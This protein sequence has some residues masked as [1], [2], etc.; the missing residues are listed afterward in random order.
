M[1]KLISGLVSFL[2]AGAVFALSQSSTT[3]WNVTDGTGTNDLVQV[4][5]SGNLKIAGSLTAGGA[6]YVTTANSTYTA[7]VAKAA[8]ALQ[9]NAVAKTN[10]IV[11]ADAK[12]NT[13]IVIGGQ[14]TS[15][16]VT[17]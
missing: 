12:T 14:I 8:S 6:T 4:D 2:V 13:I 5:T 3:V 11:S 17:E 7:T 10:V 16:V 1:K 15:W 9:P